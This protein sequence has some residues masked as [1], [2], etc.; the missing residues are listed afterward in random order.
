M[1]LWVGEVH[2]MREGDPTKCCGWKKIQQIFGKNV[3]ICQ[4]R[5]KIFASNRDDDLNQLINLNQLKI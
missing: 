3:M 5:P 2:V 1:K 4:I